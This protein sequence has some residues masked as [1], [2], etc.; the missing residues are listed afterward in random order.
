[1][2]AG[3]STLLALIATIEVARVGEA[4]RGFAV[5]AAEVKALAEQ[6]AKFTGEIEAQVEHVHS[7]ADLVSRS[8]G[9]I[10]AVMTEV[11]DITA[12]VA[13]AAEAQSAATAD[14][15][16]NIEQAY[17]VVS[18]ITGSIQTV[19]ESA[20]DTE[21]Y[22]ASTMT[23]STHLSSQSETLAHRIRDYLARVRADMLAQ[24][25]A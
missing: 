2:I 7:A 14:I 4:G 21:Q 3:Q 12:A 23:A 19:T 20:R 22:A 1:M 8:I 17:D 13:G 9:E 16:K 11:D 24:R 10:G 18:E 6:T 5:F 15:A 25:A